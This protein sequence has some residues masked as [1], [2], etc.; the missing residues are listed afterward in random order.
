MDN[1]LIIDD[2]KISEVIKKALYDKS[3]VIFLGQ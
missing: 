1:D 3:L 2:G